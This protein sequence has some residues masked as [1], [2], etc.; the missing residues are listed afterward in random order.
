MGECRPTRRSSRVNTA[1]GSELRVVSQGNWSDL[2]E[3]RVMTLRHVFWIRLWLWVKKKER[4][5]KMFQ[6]LC[7]ANKLQNTNTWQGVTTV[8][9]SARQYD[10]YFTL[11]GRA[12]RL[13][14]SGQSQVHMW[15]PDL[16]VHPHPVR[17]GW[18][19]PQGTSQV[20][21]KVDLQVIA[22]LQNSA[23]DCKSS[24][25]PLFSSE[26]ATPNLVYFLSASDGSQITDTA[27]LFCKRNKK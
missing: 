7:N 4:R 17:P 8:V 10:T 25:L 14:R 13:W 15:R 27:G 11:E 21:G 9:S 20:S 19:L 16:P 22:S 12:W 26:E 5:W 2:P 24:P 3:K 1:Q 23:S 18:K 6:L